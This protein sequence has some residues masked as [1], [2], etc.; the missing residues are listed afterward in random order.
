[1]RRTGHLFEYDSEI[2]PEQASAEVTGTM[3]RL[4]VSESQVEL[5][6]RSNSK[7]G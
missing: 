2:N 3:G 7:S 4:S 6:S 5:R 1:M